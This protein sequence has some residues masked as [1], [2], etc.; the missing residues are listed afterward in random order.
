MFQALCQFCAAIAI[1]VMIVQPSAFALSSYQSGFNHGISDGRDGCKHPNGCHWYI[2]Q[3]GKG[4]AFHSKEFDM[5]YVDGFCSVGPKAS[6]DADQATF[7][8]LKGPDSASWVS[9]K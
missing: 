7:D 5:G 9:D 4:F 8:C 6:S 2:I 3:P 1:L